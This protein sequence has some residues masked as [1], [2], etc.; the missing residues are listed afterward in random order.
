MPRQSTLA[1]F[2]ALGFDKTRHVA[3]TKQ[4]HLGCSQC[5][6]LAING[7]GSNAQQ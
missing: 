3:F 7:L 2:Q 6:P 5:E 4:Y 1:H